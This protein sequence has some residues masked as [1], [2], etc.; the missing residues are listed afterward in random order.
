MVYFF[1]RFVSIGENLQSE[2]LHQLAVHCTSTLVPFVWSGDLRTWRWMMS[3]MPSMFTE[4]SVFLSLLYPSRMDPAAYLYQCNW[5]CGHA[6]QGLLTRVAESSTGAHMLLQCGLMARLAECTVFDL[7][8]EADQQFRGIYSHRAEALQIPD[9][10]PSAQGKLEWGEILVKQSLNKYRWI[11]L[12]SL[13]NKLVT[14]NFPQHIWHR[15]F[16]RR[17]LSTTSHSQWLVVRYSRVN[18]MWKPWTWLKDVDQWAVWNT[19]TWGCISLLLPR[20]PIDWFIWRALAGQLGQAGSNKEIQPE[21]ISRCRIN[22]SAN[23]TTDCN[24]FP[25]L[26]S[27]CVL[28]CLRLWD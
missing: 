20:V 7:R 23:I 6:F 21:W 28:P 24:I 8:P 17:R 11:S 18:E 19:C 15:G 4:T 25:V 5:I 1:C 27:S 10:L 26:L 14:L 16:L 3:L 13:Y 2:Q 12:E 9:T 22:K